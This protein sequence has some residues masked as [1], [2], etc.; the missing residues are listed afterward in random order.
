MAVCK[1]TVVLGSAP[2]SARARS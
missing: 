2:W 1:L